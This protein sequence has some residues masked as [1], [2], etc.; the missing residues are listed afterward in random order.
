MVFTRET[1]IPELLDAA[2]K[3]RG[4][5]WAV[6]PFGDRFSLKSY[7]NRYVAVG[8]IVR[9]EDGLLSLECEF[10]SDEA[11]LMKFFHENPETIQH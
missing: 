11:S 8:E 6:S 7:L 10:K 1:Q 4:N 9:H 3:C 2:Q 5:V